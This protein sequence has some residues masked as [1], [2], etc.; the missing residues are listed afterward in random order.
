MTD[1]KAASQLNVYDK[2]RSV[3]SMIKKKSVPKA[4]LCAPYKI[5]WPNVEQKVQED[6]LN[7]LERFFNNEVFKKPARIKLDKESR[8]EKKKLQKNDQKTQANK[9]RKLL[10][11][12]LQ[13]VTKHAKK[14]NLSIFF[15]DRSSPWQLHRHLIQL[16]SILNCPAVALDQFSE[17][18]SPL[19]SV[20][21]VCALGFK[22]N[23]EV[24]SEQERCDYNMFE[25]LVNKIAPLCPQ[26]ILPWLE[27]EQEL[28]AIKNDAIKLVEN[29]KNN[30]NNDINNENKIDNNDC[31]DNDKIDNNDCNNNDNDKNNSNLSIDESLSSS[32]DRDNDEEDEDKSVGSN[33]DKINNDNNDEIMPDDEDNKDGNEYESCS[34]FS[35][36]YVHKNTS[37]E[38]DCGSSFTKEKNNDLWDY[39]MFR[40]DIFFKNDPTTKEKSNNFFNERASQQNNQRK[41]KFQETVVAKFL[42]NEFRI[43]KKK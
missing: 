21:R 33:C 1:K 3:R 41:R 4:V 29:A 28:L 8:K 32:D 22:K 15:V 14:N 31:N 34:E 11:I 43:K 16:C 42:K 6:I 38:C 9:F 20:S 5:I 7:E 18:I 37:S 10:A 17:K 40:S 25:K 24:T 27:C 35:N 36:L 23:Y 19:L 12:G 30:C 2:N 39:K 13:D 26:C